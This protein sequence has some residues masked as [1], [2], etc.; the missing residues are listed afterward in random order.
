VTRVASGTP[1]ARRGAPPG[2]LF[3]LVTVVAV[4]VVFEAV[5]QPA[6]G[7]A[8]LGAAAFISVGLAWV[9]RLVRVAHRGRLRATRADA[10]RWLGVPVILVLAYLAAESDVVTAVRFEVSRGAM[11][12][13]AADVMAGRQRP[14]GL[15][16]LYGVRRIEDNEDSVRVVVGGVMF[17]DVG[18][19]WFADPDITRREAEQRCRCEYAPLGGGWWSVTQTF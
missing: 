6:M 16:G 8:M 1:S 7:T 19:E 13:L 3:Y 9:L 2:W 17:D 11:D 18:F 15:V 10:L 4:L 14:P 12:A 5:S